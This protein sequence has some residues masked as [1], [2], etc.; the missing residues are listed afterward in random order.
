MG[1]L[2]GGRWP[3]ST[4]IAWTDKVEWQEVDSRKKKKEIETDGEEGE[5]TSYLS[6]FPFSF[7]PA[8]LHFKCPYYLNPWNIQKQR[9]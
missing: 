2:F 6:L 7:F 1:V 5:K 8:H 9:K 3:A 4:K